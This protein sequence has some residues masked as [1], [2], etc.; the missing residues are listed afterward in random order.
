MMDYHVV[1]RNRDT[2]QLVYH[3]RGTLTLQE[4]LAMRGQMAV[5]FPQ[6][7]YKVVPEPP[8]AQNLT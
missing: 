8:K 3:N 6:D 2:G 1:G 7:S 5:S 4:A